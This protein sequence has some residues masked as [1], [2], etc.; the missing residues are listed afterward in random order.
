[1]LLVCVLSDT[2]KH[3][4][5]RDHQALERHLQQ[6][7]F[8]DRVVLDGF[9][10]SAPIQV[11]RRQ[12]Q[13][14]FSLDFLR[15]HDP[16]MWAGGPYSVSRPDPAARLAFGEQHPALGFVR[17]RVLV[18]DHSDRISVHFAVADHGVGDVLNQRALLVERASLGHFDDH[19]GH[20]RLMLTHGPRMLPRGL[21]WQNH[22]PGSIRRPLAR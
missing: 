18:N 9:D 16:D 7:G 3:T 17:A 11:D 14:L 19:F 15:R 12:V 20:M 1:M 10:W 22:A 13:A 6:A 8:E 21:D 2:T 5:R 4:T